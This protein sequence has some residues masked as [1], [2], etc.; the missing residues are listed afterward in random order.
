M[1]SKNQLSF[2]LPVELIEQL[3]SLAKEGE[4]PS[5][6]AKRLI[7]KMLSEK[8]NTLETRIQKL[9]ERM[10]S[11]ENDVTNNV[12]EE[13]ENDVTNNVSKEIENKEESKDKEESNV[14]N[15]VS[16]EIENDVTNNVSEESKNKKEKRIPTPHEHRLKLIQLGI[17][18]EFNNEVD[19]KEILEKAIENNKN[20]E[21]RV[22][23]KELIAKLEHKTH[24][25][26]KRWNN[27]G[28]NALLNYYKLRWY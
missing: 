24:P 20:G 15:N 13:I 27:Q 26:G 6:A 11:L 16:E 14:I 21:N 9:E 2:S 25:L 3:K 28:L 18:D 19:I 10:N 12:S 7:K 22:T 4:S 5:L 8:E 17:S 1:R 23:K